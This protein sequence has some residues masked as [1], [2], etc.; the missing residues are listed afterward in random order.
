MISELHGKHKTVFE[1]LQHGVQAS[2]EKRLLLT[3]NVVSWLQL[4]DSL[5]LVHLTLLLL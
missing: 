2:E 4:L 3:D 5:E 1:F